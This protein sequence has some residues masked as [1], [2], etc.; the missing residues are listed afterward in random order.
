MTLPS[1][2]AVALLLACFAIPLSV[3]LSAS[4]CLF[5]GEACSAS[6]PGLAMLCAALVGA[7]GSLWGLCRL[8]ALVLDAVAEDAGGVRPLIGF[9]AT[10]CLGADYCAALLQD[11]WH[12]DRWV[13]VLLIV[14]GAS[15]VLSLAL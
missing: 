10:L 13:R 14:W 4:A 2:R 1:L 9:W 11:G 8:S 7:A 6:A 12:S 15:I 5:T 3:V